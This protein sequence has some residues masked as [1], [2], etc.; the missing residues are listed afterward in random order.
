MSFAERSFNYILEAFPRRDVPSAFAPL[1]SSK[2]TVQGERWMRRYAIEE[3]ALRSAGYSLLLIGYAIAFIA[4]AASFLLLGPEGGAMAI[5]PALLAPLAVASF[6]VN[7]PES[8][9]QREERRIMRESPSVVGGL[10]MSMQMQP[11]L[12]RAALFA[13]QRTDGVLSGRLREALWSSLTRAQMSVESAMM[14]MSA[15]FS[16]VNDPLRQSL[17]LIMAATRERTKEGM[18][19]LLDKANNIALGGVRDAVDRYV[20]SLSTPTMVLFSLGTLLPIMLF[21]LLPLMSL[22]TSFG[23]EA[24]GSGSVDGLAGLLL[25]V[26]PVASFLY[27]RSIL[28]RNP[29]GDGTDET[30]GW[31]RDV[32]PFLAAWSAIAAVSFIIELGEHRAYLQAAAIVLPPCAYLACNLHSGH[33]ARGRRA[34]DEKELINALFQVGNMMSAGSGMEE[35]LRAAAKNRPGGA[36]EAMTRNVLHRSAMTGCGV[37]G[38]LSEENVLRTISPLIE[39]AFI[40]VAECSERDPRYAGQVALNLAQLL[41]DLTACQ[42]KIDEKLKGIVDMM[43]STSLVFGPVVLGVTSSLFAVIGGAEAIDAIVLM[44]GIYIAQLSLIVSHFTVFLQGDGSWK[45]VA[46][47]FATR[48]PIALMI[49]AATSLICRT[50]LIS[51]L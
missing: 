15:A 38:A 8:L 50:G 30:M 16:A 31:R 21:T 49:F 6:F 13:S 4:V 42:A 25:V 26:F 10:T 9:S 33:V 3:S 7:A 45:E 37:K 27:A 14:D 2:R 47:Q 29:L 40:T 44:T 20:A 22:G 12:E 17:H 18:D 51:L 34:R 36:F 28:Q 23:S 43:R 5:F 32:V 41:S 19:R 1:L 46:H 11:S 48:T 39:A 24:E 35:A